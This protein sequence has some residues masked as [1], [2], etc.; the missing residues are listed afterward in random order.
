MVKWEVI[1]KAWNYEIN[2]NALI[3]NRKTGRILESMIYKENRFNTLSIHGK[4][5]CINATLLASLA[6][7]DK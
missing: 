2:E 4:I 1:P 7:P 5:I 6:F 3:R